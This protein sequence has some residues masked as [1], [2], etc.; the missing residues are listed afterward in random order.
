MTSAVLVMCSMAFHSPPTSAAGAAHCAL[1]TPPTW[2]YRAPELLLA[3]TSYTT[4]VDLW[5][6][7]C[8]LAEMALLRPLFA[9]EDAADQFTEIVDLLGPPCPGEMEAMGVGENLLAAT[10]GLVGLPGEIGEGRT[11]VGRLLGAYP[12]LAELLNMLLIYTPG[13]RWGRKALYF[14]LPR[15]RAEEVVLDLFFQS[16]VERREGE[17]RC[18]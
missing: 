6:L 7:A 13:S 9:G 17:E 5:S 1:I 18:S 14:H 10:A 3:S 11:R 16:V 4:A 8:V 15:L 12:G 2:F